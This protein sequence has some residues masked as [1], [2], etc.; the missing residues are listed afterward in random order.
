MFVCSRMDS[1]YEHVRSCGVRLEKEKK[2]RLERLS[3]D[4]KPAKSSEEK[5][6]TKGNILQP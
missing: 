6:G 3:T 5:S 4:T 2:R 1:D